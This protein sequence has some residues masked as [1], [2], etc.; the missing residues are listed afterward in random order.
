MLFPAKIMEL[1]VLNLVLP[2][3]MGR[4]ALSVKTEGGKCSQ[5]TVQAWMFSPFFR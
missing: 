2:P 5:T 4:Q 1:F 3:F